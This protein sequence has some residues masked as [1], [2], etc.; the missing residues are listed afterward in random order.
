MLFAAREGE[1][2]RFEATGLPELLVEGLDL[3]AAQTVL[4]AAFRE[5][6]PAVRERLLAEAAGNPLAL[7]ELPAGLSDDQLTGDA[8]LPGA[9]PLTPRLQAVFRQRVERLPE[10]SQK[11]LLILA[12]DDT[13]D[14]A[15]VVRAAAQMNLPADALDP[16]ETA[17]L[18]RTSNG[19]VT[20]RH[21][22]VRSALYDGAT[23]SQR[24]RVHAAL[25]AVLDGDEH[26]DR[27]VWHQ[28]MAT[29][30][31][32]EE[33]AAALEASARRS[34]L[35]AA[36]SSAASAFLRAVE[37]STDHDRRVSR[38]A[39][40]AAA[41]WD[42]G[43]PDR[44]REAIAQAL[45]V[46]S[47]ELRVRL[48]Q[49]SGAIEGRCG[50]VPAALPQ[51]LEGAD[52]TD[53]ASLTL[54]L[55]VDAAE[56]A[57]LTGQLETVV[58]ICERGG[59]VQARTARDRLMAALLSGFAKVFSGDQRAARPLLEDAM[60][61]ADVLDDP[62]ALT[63]AASA[64]SVSDLGGAGLRYA[65]RAVE[66][67]RRRGV[68]SLLPQA[69]EQQ[70]YE[71]ANSSSFE[72]A[73]AAAEEG[74]RLSLDVGHGH[75][76]H[77][78]NMARAETVWGRAADA[79]RHLEEALAIGRQA[80]NSFLIGTAD[81]MLGFLELAVGRP[82]DAA[83]RMLAVTDLSEP[84][85]NPLVALPAIPDAVEA[86]TRGG[87]NDEL[88]GRLAAFESW[89]AAASSDTR[90]ALLARCQ[91]LLGVRPPDQAFGEAVARAQALPPLQRA[92]TQLLYGEW[93]RRER[94]RQDA[95]VHLR[96]AL[97]LF[98]SLGAA[99]FAERAEAELRATGETARK[100]D[101]ST[102]DE[103]TPQELQIAGLVAQGMTNR[104]IAS[105]L[106]LSPRTIDYHLHKVF[107]KL[108]IASRTELVR[109][110]LSARA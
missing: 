13:G 78:T 69:L 55:L 59:S 57:E 32:D 53:D 77:L 42:A 76:W 60:R 105:Q 45:P 1:P 17:D 87:R 5:A 4:A 41:A 47:G 49:L 109:D 44:A 46:A 85:V 95:R 35:R 14:V 73:Y 103:L 38:V 16:A 31:A 75:G 54:E 37:L 91:A 107:S 7:L 99:P 90:R 83:D 66:C 68:L 21:P 61:E 63:L 9:I 11:V 22:L 27:R 106:Y 101:P 71:L 97:E 20:F 34:Q 110:G 81:W 80:G 10:A 64:A 2:R 86:A 6:V 108:G 84:S 15:T 28:A 29:L 51:L 18:I 39:A 92:R 58:E 82:V 94:R 62:R 25:A 72:L 43:Q 33:V 79:R 102:L 70:A 40:A 36:H 23:M 12:A 96:S 26:A 100:R 19:G 50:S 56:A 30:G 104:E 98:R 3:T 88:G 89:T 65:N 48:L 74:Y 8:A 24:Q 93:L 67:A 52:A